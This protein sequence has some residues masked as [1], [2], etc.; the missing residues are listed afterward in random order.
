MKKAAY[1]NKLDQGRVQ[2]MLCPH[3]CVIADGKSGLCGARKNQSGELY[4]ANYG[5][6][7]A[8]SFDPIEKKPLFHYYPG[9][10]ILS[11]GTVGCN[12]RCPFCQNYTISR[13]FDEIPV[14]NLETSPPEELLKALKA[15]LNHQQERY[16]PGIAYTYSE[17]M[18][19]FEYVMDTG[20]LL[21][22]RGLKNVLVSNGYIEKEPLRELLTVIDAINIDLKAFTDENYRRIGGRLNPVLDTIKICKEAGVH[23]ELTT[24]VVTNLND[25]EEEIKHLIDWVA[26]IDPK[27]PMHFSRYFPQYHYH[28]PPTS[29]GFMKLVQDMARKKLHYVYLGNIQEESDTLCPGCGNILI[30]REGY[31]ISLPGLE[32][33][34]CASCGRIS[35]IILPEL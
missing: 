31:N 23:V 25:Q 7:S 32:N 11:I 35:D 22:S 29:P 26:D 9:K 3:H 28:E 4:T 19:W 33:D 27:I 20:R 30:K 13:Y 34:T 24:L 21:K 1:F 16:F 6:L 17:P 5:V 2:C 8:L 12:L 14:S 18:V 10:T 15:K